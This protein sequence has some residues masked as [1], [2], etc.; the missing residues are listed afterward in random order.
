MRYLTALILVWF[1]LHPVNLAEAQ[2]SATDQSSQPP[3][4]RAWLVGDHVTLD[5]SGVGSFQIGVEVPPDHHGYLDKGDDGLLIPF[6]FTFASL[7]AQGARVAVLSRPPGERDD[8]V[9]ATVLR[10]SGE[11][12]FRLDT[13]GA[14]L[15]VDGAVPA[16]LRYQIC[17]DIT[18]I[19]YPP[20]TTEIPL[21]IVGASVAERRAGT[22]VQS[23]PSESR[24]S[25]AAA[26]VSRTPHPTDTPAFL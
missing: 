18:N 9:R 7:E 13:A 15:S 25:K 20:R 2:L 24:A 14:T 4:A 22:L 12:A 21:P 10:G 16:T 11:F 17:N 6:A 5:Q 8:D 19:C 23:A 26:S 3:G 1:S